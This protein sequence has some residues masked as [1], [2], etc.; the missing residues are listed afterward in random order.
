MILEF[1]SAPA[2]DGRDLSSKLEWTLTRAIHHFSSFNRLLFLL[3]FPLF[4][5]SSYRTLRDNSDS[6]TAMAPS[7]DGVL[8]AAASNKKRPASVSGSS[9]GSSDDSSRRKKRR[10][11]KNGSSKKRSNGDFSVPGAFAQRRNSLAKASRD[12]RDEPLPKKKRAVAEGAVV[13]TRSPSPVIDFDG[14][15]RPSTFSFFHPLVCLIV[16]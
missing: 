9:T 2:A 15:S 1:C 4:I 12:P 13:K 11:R 8:V 10:D 5:F 16:C 7:E 14:L 6:T 3:L